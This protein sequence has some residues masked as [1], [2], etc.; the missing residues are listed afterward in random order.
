[1][2]KALI[3]I[4]TIIS[5]S[6]NAQRKRTSPVFDADTTRPQIG[7]YGITVID[8]QPY[9]VGDSGNAQRIEVSPLFIPTLSFGTVTD[10]AILP[11][12]YEHIIITKD[13]NHVVFPPDDSLE[14]GKRYYISFMGLRG[15]CADTILRWMPYDTNFYLSFSDTIF[16]KKGVKP[17]Q[18]TYFTMY[19][20]NYYN[21]VTGYN[22]PSFFRIYQN[23][24]IYLEFIENRWYLF[25]ADIK[26]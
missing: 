25:F 15:F 6:I 11:I 24:P 19:L 3:F 5:F 2:K 7:T 4:F 14:N 12:D 8:K 26:F 20:T 9:L 16:Y 10:T 18:D 13:S 17:F 1:M 23:Y 22:R 21:T